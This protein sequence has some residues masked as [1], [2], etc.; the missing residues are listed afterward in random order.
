MSFPTGFTIQL[1][2]S[3]RKQKGKGF[4][5]AMSLLENGR[6]I[7]TTWTKA[8]LHFPLTHSQL[9]GLKA[10]TLSLLVFSKTLNW[11]VE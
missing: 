5:N 4:G 10:F 11:K 3:K 7:S 1:G 6:S 2:K 8:A 9:L